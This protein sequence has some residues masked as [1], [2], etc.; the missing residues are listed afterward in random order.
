MARDGRHE[1]AGQPPPDDGR[2]GPRA[3][4]D[5]PRWCPGQLDLNRNPRDPSALSGTG[6]PVPTTC[7]HSS[8]HRRPDDGFYTDHMTW[9]HDQYHRFQAARSAP[10]HDL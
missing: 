7:Y 2:H 9:N 3:D 4:P 6:F 5:D 10:A 1:S 8:T